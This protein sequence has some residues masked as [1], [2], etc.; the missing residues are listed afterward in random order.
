MWFG[1]ITIDAKLENGKIILFEPGQNLYQYVGVYKE[2]NRDDNMELIIESNNPV[3]LWVADKIEFEEDD[4]FFDDY[5]CSNCAD[6]KDKYAYCPY[7]G[8]KL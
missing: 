3:P 2:E 7:C 8:T 1:H 6:S 5:G 4:M